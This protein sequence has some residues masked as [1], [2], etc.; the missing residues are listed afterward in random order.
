[1]PSLKKHWFTYAI[2]LLLV[3]SAVL[4]WGIWQKTSLDKTSQT[5]VAE[6]IET[7]FRTDRYSQLVERALDAQIN[8]R[9]ASELVRYVSAL[10]RTL[11]SLE[12]ISGVF[13]EAQVPLVNLS[14]TPTIANYE[15]DL[16][17]SAGPGIL[18]ITLHHIEG[19]WLMSRFLV[20]SQL[21]LN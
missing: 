4:A 7:A 13:G 1:M 12:E 9:P 21:L 5:A 18:R 11:G 20:E 10:N 6:I 14:S 16:K 2:S 17:F 15:A 8:E 19:T 3:A